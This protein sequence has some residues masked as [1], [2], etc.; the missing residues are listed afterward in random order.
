MSDKAT[1][2]LHP[3]AKALIFD[4]DGTLIDSIGINWIAMDA[5][6]R[7]HNIV[8]EF[9]EFVSMTGRSLEEIVDIIVAKHGTGNEDKRDIIEHKRLVAN[10]YADDVKPIDVV[11][12]VAR[13][14]HGKL[15]MAVGTGS[16]RNRAVMM[17]RSSGLLPLFD[18]IVA[19][20]DVLKH[21]PHPETFLR[22]AELMG[23]EP[24]F[25]QVFEDGETG[26]EAARV[27][28][29]IATDVRPFIG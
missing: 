5:A 17:M 13:L 10:S 25:C 24:K 21:K 11:A 2:L 9:Q 8:I 19:A 26:L 16:D 27:A 22:C 20:D 15:P 23:V 1:N 3:D 6:L 4:L 18:H 12:N 28:G 29:M 7:R 14:C